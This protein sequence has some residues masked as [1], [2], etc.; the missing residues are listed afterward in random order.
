MRGPY[1][2]YEVPMKKILFSAVLAAAPF[3]ML[4]SAHAETWLLAAAACPPW[5]DIPGKPELSANINGACEK[6]IDLFVDGFKTTF[7]V[8]DDHITTLLN[9]DA[10][11][12][13]VTRA[14]ADLAAK[15]KPEDRV[16]LYVN[17][18]GGQVEAM[19]KGYE[20]K[21]EIFAWYTEQKPADFTK[22]TEDGSWMSVR[23]FRDSV[24]AIMANEI[25][26]VIEACDAS[27]A[28]E[29]FVDNFNNGVG[30]RGD[31]WPGRE[32]I[33]FSAHAEQV[34]NFTPDGKEAVFTKTWSDRLKN[35]HDDTLFDSF[36]AARIATHRAVREKC[37]KGETHAELLKDWKDY[38]VLCTQMPTSW[39]PFGLLDDI[40]IPVRGFGEKP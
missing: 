36:E 21:D 38:K 7:N 12:D 1:N 15:A 39:D 31:N 2:L 37:A 35:G 13:K 28:M 17:T 19:Y 11:T 18:H 16:I 3:A 14:I 24:N 22:A 33:I 27:V 5:K 9:A 40:T 8:S 29:D 25:V 10:T 26:T 23:A 6:D 34:A 32:A 30:G 20:V 4:Q